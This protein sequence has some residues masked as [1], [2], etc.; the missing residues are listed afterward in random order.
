MAEQAAV[1]R[2][3]AET[4]SKADIADEQVSARTMRELAK[5]EAGIQSLVESAEEALKTLRESKLTKQRVA[6]VSGL[7]RATL[8]NNEVIDAYVKARIEDNPVGSLAQREDK[9]RK[10]LE[11]ERRKV[12]LMQERDGEIILL[13]KKVEE[14][15]SELEVLR[16]NAENA[17]ACSKAVAKPKQLKAVED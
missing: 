3:V 14:L 8:Y 6:D 5:V 15:E 1:E 16:E 12:R 11:E 4:L 9:L 13:R 7:A 2:V 17:R 10:E